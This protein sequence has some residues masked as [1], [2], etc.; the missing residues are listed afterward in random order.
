MKT[1][2]IYEL[3]SESKSD[4]GIKYFLE[5]RKAEKAYLWEGIDALDDQLLAA[6]YGG[7]QC[8]VN[9]TLSAIELRVPDEFEPA[10]DRAINIEDFEETS[11]KIIKTE[12]VG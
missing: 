9:V 11:R 10:T 2:Q 6:R 12:K 1:I 4:T 5:R 7:E 8:G 3:K